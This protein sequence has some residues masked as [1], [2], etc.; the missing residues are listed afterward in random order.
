M[1]HRL[2]TYLLSYCTIEEGKNTMIVIE[3][4]HLHEQDN[5]WGLSSMFWVPI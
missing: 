3:A 5:H 4:R 1:P 2:P